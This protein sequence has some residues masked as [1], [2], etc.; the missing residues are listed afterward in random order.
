LSRCS[1]CPSRHLDLMRSAPYSKWFDDLYSSLSDRSDPSGTISQ[2]SSA[3]RGVTDA[4]QQTDDATWQESV[5]SKSSVRTMAASAGEL[6]RGALPLPGFNFVGTDEDLNAGGNVVGLKSVPRGQSQTKVPSWA[7]TNQQRAADRG[8]RGEEGTERGTRE[9]M[10]IGKRTH[11]HKHLDVAC[12]DLETGIEVPLEIARSLDALARDKHAPMPKVVFRGKAGWCIVQETEHADGAVTRAYVRD[13]NSI[14]VKSVAVL[15]ASLQSGQ[16]VLRFKSGAY[17]CENCFRDGCPCAFYI[18]FSRDTC[19]HSV[20]AGGKVQLSQ[21]GQKIANE[22]AGVK[23]VSI[24]STFTHECRMSSQQTVIVNEFGDTDLVRMQKVLVQLDTTMQILAESHCDMHNA[25]ATLQRNGISMERDKF[26]TYYAA[27]QRKVEAAL[28]RA[29]QQL[30]SMRE[31]ALRTRSWV[32]TL[33][34]PKMKKSRMAC[35]NGVSQ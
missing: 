31:A 29:Q 19:G 26:Y 22:Y 15:R 32:Q 3:T 34:V 12:L 8:A 16:V 18:S 35:P 9:W 28:P 23:S 13:L 5:S 11:G 4:T 1:G 10:H 7:L 24:S 25:Y 27:L 33:C 14:E 20:L 17:V 30:F 6:Q 21:F 2:Q